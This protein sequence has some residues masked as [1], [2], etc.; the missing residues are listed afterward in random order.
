MNESRDTTRVG[1]VP[2][3]VLRVSRLVSSKASS[4][5]G[6]TPPAP[7]FLRGGDDARLRIR[8]REVLFWRLGQLWRR[9]TLW[10]LTHDCGQTGPRGDIEGLAKLMCGIEEQRCPPRL[11]GPSSQ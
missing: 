8:P 5:R 10:R 6:A 1:G 2:G 7:P 9:L 11:F 4:P 3:A